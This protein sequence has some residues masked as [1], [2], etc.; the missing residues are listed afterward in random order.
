MEVGCAPSPSARPGWVVHFSPVFHLQT[1][2]PTYG[3]SLPEGGTCSVWG[4]TIDALSCYSGL[5]QNLGRTHLDI[6]VPP[7]KLEAFDNPASDGRKRAPPGASCVSSLPVASINPCY[8][9]TG[10]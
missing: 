9:V 3:K 5:V 1:A 8:L 2:H 7:E 4:G 6:P 10:L